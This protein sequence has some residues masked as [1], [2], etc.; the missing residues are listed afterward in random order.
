MVNRNTLQIA[1]YRTTAT[2]IVTGCYWD[3]GSGTFSAR[4]VTPKDAS[5]QTFRP[6]LHAGMFCPIIPG[7]FVP[8]YYEVPLYQT[9]YVRFFSFFF[10]FFFFDK[11][12]T[13]Q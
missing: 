6:I 9:V 2:G 8:K 5:L 11:Q 4:D 3:E 7:R 10:F 1:A 13:F 12:L